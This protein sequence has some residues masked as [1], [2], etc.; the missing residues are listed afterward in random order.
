MTR[1][2][3]HG[4]ALD[5]SDRNVAILREGV[6]D[7]DWSPRV[8][9]VPVAP[10]HAQAIA[11]ILAGA[12]SARPSTHDLLGDI[13]SE[14]GADVVAVTLAAE[15]RDQYVAQLHLVRDER[16][17]AIPCEPGDALALALSWECACFVSWDLA[18]HHTVL[19]EEEDGPELERFRQ[20]MRGIEA[21]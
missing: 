9:L 21:I 12:C 19:L 2:H 6:G 3:V 1:M 14:L 15:R 13:V 17:F 18:E 5:Q 11:R 20:L 8:L 7:G 4:I 16:D 10:R